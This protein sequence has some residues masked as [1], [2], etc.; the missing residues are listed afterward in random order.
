MINKISNYSYLLILC[1]TINHIVAMDEN[2]DNRSFKMQVSI[3][4]IGTRLAKE[5]GYDWFEKDI[6]LQL[7]KGCDRGQLPLSEARKVFTR[8]FDTSYPLDKS[9][10]RRKVDQI[11]DLAQ[12]PCT[13]TRAE[14]ADRRRGVLGTFLYACG[15]AIIIKSADRR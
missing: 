3:E 1:S 15:I 12:R 13:P 7:I 4:K 11:I 5:M 2:K 9:K 14:V 6:T 10:V 8:L